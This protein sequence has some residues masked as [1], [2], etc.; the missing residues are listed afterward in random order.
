AFIWVAGQYDSYVTAYE[1]YDVNGDEI[2]SGAGA[3]VSPVNYTVNCSNCKKPS[4]LEANN[5]TTSSAELTWTA[6]NAETAW[7]ICVN[8]D[9]ENLINVTETTYTLANLDEE[10]DY[11]VKV[12]ANCGE[13]QSGWIEESFTTLS[14]CPDPVDMVVT[15]TTNTTANISWDGTVDSYVVRYAPGTIVLSED[16]ENGMPEGWT[17]ID[18]DGDGDV[19]ANAGMAGHESEGCI[20]SKSYDNN[21]GALTPDNWLITPAIELPSDASAIDLQF[22]ANGQDASYANEHYGV[23]VSTTTTDPS[24]FTMLWAET[25]DAEGG[26][27]RVQGVWG[28]KNTDLTAYAGQT[29]YIALRHFNTSDQF[30]LNVDDFAIYAVMP[31]DWEETTT[32]ETS[33]ELTNLNANTTYLYQMNGVCDGAANGTWTPVHTFTTEPNTYTITATAGDNGTILPV[34]ETVVVEGEDL[35]ITIEAATGYRIESV[36]VDGGTEAETDVT[37]QL[38]DGVYT[39]VNVTADHTIHATFVAVPEGEYVVTVNATEN[40]TIAPNGIQTVA[41]NGDFTF[42]VTPAP[43]YGIAE[44]TVNGVEVTLDEN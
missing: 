9:E 2:F 15:A 7:Q 37:A 20:T 30:Y 23:Y 14:S 16:F 5:V 35:E 29:V 44:V 27:H 33:I 12:R 25:M 6:G 31:E 13:D 32:T 18:V 41:E 28:E 4:A 40:G 3:M 17:T 38:T 22:Y 39:F 10:T 21:Y 34:D 36:V 1:V 11:T 43:C 26:P 8:G 42:T 19:W 24:A